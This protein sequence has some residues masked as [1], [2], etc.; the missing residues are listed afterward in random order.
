[1]DFLVFGLRVFVIGPV[2]GG[3]GARRV[4]VSGFGGRLVSN[5]QLPLLRCQVPAPE[6]LHLSLSSL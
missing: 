4:G 2:F 5:F 1:M 3:E 6:S